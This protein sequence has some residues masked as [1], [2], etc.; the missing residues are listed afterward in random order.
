MLFWCH[1]VSQGAF[2]RGQY[3]LRERSCLQRKSCW[4]ERMLWLDD[5]F[6]I[7]NGNE[8]IILFVR[9]R[10]KRRLLG[11]H[12]GNTGRIWFSLLTWANQREI[13]CNS[14]EQHCRRNERSL[15]MEKDACL[16]LL[17]SLFSVISIC[18]LGRFSGKQSFPW[19]RC[20]D[21]FWVNM[22]E[23]RR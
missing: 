8:A 13:C 18:T 22:N 7:F 14:D 16:F 20:V 3:S 21:F 12:S 4:P 11:V 9:F 6:H 23:I 19:D 15:R 1:A 17:S 5:F 10:T 2:S